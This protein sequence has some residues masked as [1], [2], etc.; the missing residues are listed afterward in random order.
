MSVA[1]PCIFNIVAWTRRQAAAY[2]GRAG[3]PST[4]L[5]LA[6]ASSAGGSRL[7]G[8]GQP[9]PADVAGDKVE[10]DRITAKG[11]I[12]DK[13]FSL[14]IAMSRRANGYKQPVC[15]V[16]K[17]FDPVQAALDA[18][19]INGHK[20]NLLG[21]YSSAMK[22]PVGPF[23]VLKVARPPVYPIWVYE[24]REGAYALGLSLFFLN[25]FCNLS[26]VP[27]L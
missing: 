14:I 2:M 7:F 11:D 18:T 8:L 17:V 23:I 10:S 24:E 25:R 27:P 4:A 12:D 6:K 26:L 16:S 19:I 9:R 15:G 3:R 22:V 20:T 1:R 21:G 5:R 13:R